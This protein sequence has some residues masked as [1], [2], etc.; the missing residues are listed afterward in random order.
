M[1]D[2]S[3]GP[4][5][6][7]DD[8]SHPGALPLERSHRD[9]ADLTTPKSENMEVNGSSTDDQASVASLDSDL[10]AHGDGEPS[11]AASAV[12]FSRSLFEGSPAYKQGRKRIIKDK[13]TSGARAPTSGTAYDLCDD[14]GSESEGLPHSDYSYPTSHDNRL[15][16]AQIGHDDMQPL[17]PSQSSHSLPPIQHEVLPELPSANPTAVPP[18]PNA[19]AYQQ[20]GLTEWITLK[21]DPSRILSPRHVTGNVIRP[22]GPASSV[23]AIPSSTGA[24]KGFACPL[25]SCGRLFKRLEHLKRHVRTHTQERPFEC[26]RCSKRFSRSDNLTQHIKTHEK[27]DRGERMK[28]EAS[29]STESDHNPFLEGDMDT[30]GARGL[31]GLS[32]VDDY[33]YHSM[34]PQR[35]PT[36]WSD[37]NI[38]AIAYLNRTPS[39]YAAQHKRDTRPPLA[40]SPWQSRRTEGVTVSTRLDRTARVRK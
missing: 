6:S 16:K 19:A 8:P 24:G 27:A 38:L 40:S 5:H 13:R 26:R 11:P 32:V 23:T 30:P 21:P 36:G 37:S 2:D 12:L 28:T 14:S 10:A 1:D 3:H 22:D 7:L 29:E 33:P 18:T 17:A 35:F 20:H 4:C 9:N 25:I 39:I 15:A 34:D 31:R